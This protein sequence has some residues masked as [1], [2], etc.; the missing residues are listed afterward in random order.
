MS[1][2]AMIVIIILFGISI[3]VVYNKA[4]KLGVEKGRQEILEENL[5]RLDVK[6]SGCDMDVINLVNRLV[7]DGK[8]VTTLQAELKSKE[9]S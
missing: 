8:N 5:L 6:K 2:S 4:F 9:A 7:T 3:Y 1:I